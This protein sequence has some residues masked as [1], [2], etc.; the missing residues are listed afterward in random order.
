M[1]NFSDVSIYVN[2]IP[3]NANTAEFG[4]TFAKFGNIKRATILTD[5]YR[6]NVVSRGIGFVDFETPEGAK[7]AVAAQKIELM[8]RELHIKPARQRVRDTLFIGGLVE[9]ATK[10]DVTA[11]FPDPKPTDVRVIPSKEANKK[12]FAFIRFA[13][14]SDM[15]KAFT[16]HKVVTIKGSES[17]VRYS[18]RQLRN[19][20]NRRFRR[21]GPKRAAQE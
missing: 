21:N 4:E 19:R 8:G 7:A 3:F 20:P 13:T 18:R 15:R 1:N 6:G 10:E 11:A 16:D 12:G 9:G 14:E 17:T 5:N 2:N